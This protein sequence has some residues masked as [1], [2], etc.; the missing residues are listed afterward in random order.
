MM[1]IE[2]YSLLGGLSSFEVSFIRGSTVYRL[3]EFIL[4]WVDKHYNFTTN[5]SFYGFLLVQLNIALSQEDIDAILDEDKYI[6]IVNSM[7]W[8]P[9]KM[10]T[11]ASKVEF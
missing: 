7:G 4:V 5:W 3:L 1:C 8:P 9:T 10:I 11:P 2:R 6:A